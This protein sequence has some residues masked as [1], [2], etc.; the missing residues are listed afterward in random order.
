M[1]HQALQL[2]SGHCSLQDQN[3][4]R[5]AERL[6]TN[7]SAAYCNRHMLRCELARDHFSLLTRAVDWCEIGGLVMEFGVATGRTINH[8]AELLPQREIYGFDWF[9]GLPESWR[10]GFGRGRFAQP[11]PVIRPN[12]TLVEGLFEE[13]LQ[14]FLADHDGPVALMHVDCDLYSSTRVVLSALTDRIVAGTVIVFDE[15]FNYPGW[16]QHEFKA[17][18]D[19]TSEHGRRYEYLGFVPTHQQVCARVTR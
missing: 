4:I 2:A 8:L 11:L 3:L 10:P 13:T 6:A 15:Y 7:E 19:W 12:V 14:P 18:Q 9:Q 5:A 1:G 17:F 16:Q